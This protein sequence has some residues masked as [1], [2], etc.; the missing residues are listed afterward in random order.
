MGENIINIPNTIT[1]IRLLLIFPFIYLL[2]NGETFF[3][4]IV[5]IMA[6]LSDKL[7][8]TLAIRL[9][10]ETQ[11]G[12]FFDALTDTIMLLSGFVVLYL[13]GYLPVYWVIAILA[14]RFVSA[15]LIYMRPK[16]KFLTT[17]YS[18]VAALFIYIIVV[19]IL[20]EFYL[21]VYGLIIGVYIL[22]AIHWYEIIKVRRNK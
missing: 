8:G 10:Q 12:K 3:A 19:S 20:S 21:A 6:V 5:F 7:D 1:F 18:R 2:V 4:L 16:I 11:F 9:K 22:T 17:I 14:P 13:L 15:L